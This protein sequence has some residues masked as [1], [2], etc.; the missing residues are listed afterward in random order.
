MLYKVT[1]HRV[2]R[3]GNKNIEKF[4]IGSKCL[5]PALP[6]KVLMI[7]GQTGAGKSTL[8][9]AIVNYIFDIK[10]GDSFRFVLIPESKVQTQSQTQCIT[11]YTFHHVQGSNITFNLT[12]IDT[13]GFG[14]T[15]GLEKDQKLV[16]LIR[17]FFSTP[18]QYG[19]DHLDGITLSVKAHDSR[20]TH[21]QRYIFYS[22][23]SIFGKD[24]G[25]NI[26]VMATHADGGTPKVFEAL[27]EENIPIDKKFIFNNSALFTPHNDANDFSKMFWEMGVNSIKSFLTEF[28][29]VESKSLTLTKEV[30]KERNVNWKKKCSRLFNKLILVFKI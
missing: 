21:T 23:M 30:L 17:E 20:L 11:A 6:N 12:V 29:K 24:V 16:D 25:S 15:E 26:F 9:N 7:L 8:I 22:V 1:S 28:S 27:K 3:D 14:D 13:P 10:W 4:E 5:D 2:Y 18:A 19:I